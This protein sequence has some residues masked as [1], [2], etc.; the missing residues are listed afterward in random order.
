[1]MDHSQYR[2]AVLTDPNDPDPEVRAHLENCAQCRAFTAK[3]QSFESNL[4]R[5]LRIDVP[6][7]APADV[8]SLAS[9]RSPARQPAAGP[10]W[11][12][13]AASALLGAVLVGTI[14]LALPTRSLAAAVV[15]HMA[16]EPEAWTTEAAVPVPALDAVLQN[17]KIRLMPQAGTVSYASSCAFRGYV[18]PHLVVQ[19]ESGPVTVMVLVHET[20]TKATQFDEQGYRGVIVPVKDHGALAVL[21]KDPQADAATVE[22][23]AQ[24]VRESII[25]TR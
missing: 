22:K 20:R 11:V 14:W 17:A 10:R 4:A 7:A 8:A 2:T 19:S 15:A 5:A 3:L 25:W 13:L 18:V 21:V 6:A 9:R 24:R 23:I 12:A 16:G 1:M